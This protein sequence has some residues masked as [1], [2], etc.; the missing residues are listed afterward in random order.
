MSPLEGL[1]VL[2]REHRSWVTVVPHGDDASVS[3]LMLHCSC[4]Q[5]VELLGSD[6]PLDILNVLSDQHVGQALSPG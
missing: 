2:A 5:W 3:R 6:L 1:K 4:G